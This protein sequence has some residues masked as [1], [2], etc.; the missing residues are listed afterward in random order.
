MEKE[1][2]SKQYP[3][4]IL[5]A[6]VLAS[7]KKPCK[8][9]R[10]S[11]K[12]KNEYWID[13]DSTVHE[14]LYYLKEKYHSQIDIIEEDNNSTITPVHIVWENKN[15]KNLEIKYLDNNKTVFISGDSK[16]QCKICSNYNFSQ[17]R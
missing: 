16:V 9:E 12:K 17:F 5:P 2:F 6:D 15:S 8:G 10:K 7:F 14:A 4:I 1:I 11:K 3:E 13:F